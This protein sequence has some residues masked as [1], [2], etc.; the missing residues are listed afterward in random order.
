M[1]YHLLRERKYTIDGAKEFLKNN[2]KGRRK[3][4][5]DRTIAKVKIF[6]A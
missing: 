1:I 4:P 2:K 5:D 3:I 6:S